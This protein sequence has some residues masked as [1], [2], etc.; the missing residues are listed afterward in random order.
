MQIECSVPNRKTGRAW[1][2]EESIF[3]MVSFFL[4]LLSLMKSKGQKRS[5][6][7]LRVLALE[8]KIHLK[9]KLF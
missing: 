8:G 3:T 2:K 7:G 1:Q 4:A 9:E 6:A 5:L